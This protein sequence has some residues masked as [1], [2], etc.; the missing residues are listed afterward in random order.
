MY[1]WQ[2][3]LIFI[4]SSMNIPRYFRRSDVYVDDVKVAL[5]HFGFTPPLP[6]TLTIHP[7][8]IIFIAKCVYNDFGPST[9]RYRRKN[10]VESPHPLTNLPSFSCM[11]VPR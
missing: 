9:R 11:S 8:L 3:L 4:K 1:V 7:L 6:T 2:R 5:C 10:R